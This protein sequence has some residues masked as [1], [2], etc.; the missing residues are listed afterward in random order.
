MIDL[1]STDTRVINI[2]ETWLP[3]FDFRNQKWQYRGEL[4][5]HAVKSLSQRVNMIAAIDT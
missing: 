2:D 4:N 5:R 3:H 1:L